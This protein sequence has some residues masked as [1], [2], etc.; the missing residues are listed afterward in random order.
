MNKLNF[1]EEDFKRSQQ[2]IEVES[3]SS[4]NTNNETSNTTKNK[5]ALV[6]HEYNS[7]DNSE[8]SDIEKHIER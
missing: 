3:N 6:I 2:F 5:D 1:E 8:I 4:N 7:R